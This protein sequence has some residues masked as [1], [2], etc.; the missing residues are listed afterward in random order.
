[1]VSRRDS[2]T[3]REAA[4]ARGRAPFA[5]ASKCAGARNAEAARARSRANRDGAAK[6]RIASRAFDDHA[7]RATRGATRAAARPRAAAARG[8]R[9]AETFRVRARTWRREGC[10]YDLSNPRAW[11]FLSRLEMFRAL[12]RFDWPA[13][14]YDSRGIFLFEWDVETATSKA[15]RVFSDRRPDETTRRKRVDDRSTWRVSEFTRAHR[16][17]RGREKC[18]GYDRSS[19]RRRLRQPLVWP[20]PLL[21]GHGRIR[22]LAYEVLRYVLVPVRQREVHGGVPLRVAR[23]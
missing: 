14:I 13:R 1:M 18:Y 16:Q 19:A 17:R 4:V 3:G 20:E 12:R 10:G 5:R 8:E 21:V 7:R 9:A 6:W 23:V 11:V 22:S 2:H 15:V